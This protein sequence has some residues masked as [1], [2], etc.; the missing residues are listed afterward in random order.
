MSIYEDLDP[1]SLDAVK[2]YP[3]AS[4]PSKV[5]L[6]AFAKP[7]NEE[8]SL[9]DYLASF[10]NILAAESLRDLA[11]RMRRAREVQKP[12]IWGVGGHVIETGLAPLI[13][14]LMRRGY[15]TALATN[16]SVLVHDAEIAMVGSTSE[17]VDATLGE[18]IFGGADETGKLLNQAAIDG[19][20]DSIGLGEALGRALANSKPAH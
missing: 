8:S 9:S 18:G 10:P 15:V 20:R 3:L 4:R 11:R 13:I 5:T 1:L 2:T 7:I 19:V 14:D 16:G 6:R 12:I 17:D